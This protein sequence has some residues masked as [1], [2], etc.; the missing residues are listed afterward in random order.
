LIVVDAS[1][2]VKWIAPEEYSEA[3][4]ALAGRSDLIAPS[5]LIVEVANAVRRKVRDGELT[6]EQGH[7]G[8]LRVNQRVNLSPPTIDIVSRAFEMALAMNHPIY[9]CIHLSLA[10]STSSTFA[11]FDDKFGQLATEHGL[12]ELVTVLS[13]PGLVQ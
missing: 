10:E 1:V 9:D 8:L 4:L 5:L 11:T 2:A 7:I 12:G 13:G 3:A 6:S